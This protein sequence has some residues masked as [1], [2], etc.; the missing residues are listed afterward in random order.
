MTDRKRVFLIDTDLGV[1][2]SIALLM[3]LADPSIEIRALFTVHGNTKIEQVNRN[4]RQ[5]LEYTNCEL[6][7]YPGSAMPLHA[8]PLEPVE[9][10]GKDGL[11]NVSYELPEPKMEL[12]DKHAALVMVDLIN[13]A[14]GAGEEITLVMLGP[15][16][17]L[18]LALTLDPEIINKLPNLVIMGGAFEARGNSSTVAEFNFFADPEAAAVVFRAGFSNVILLPWETTLKF[19]LL[20]DNYGQLCEI[21]TSRADLMKRI[22]SLTRQFLEGILKFPGLLLPD[23]LAMACALDP[24]IIMNEVH[25]HSSIE[26]AGKIGRGLLACDWNGINQAKPNV[27][28]VTEIDSERLFNRLQSCLKKGGG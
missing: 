28:I 17:N 5:V 25:I 6:P 11:G 4:V 3:A 7:I 2:D 13:E 23:P 21:G 18:A 15:L 9:I 10:M 8:Q 27:H 16:T 1:D 24:S 26:L 19:P 22:T 14:H 20:W 12:Q